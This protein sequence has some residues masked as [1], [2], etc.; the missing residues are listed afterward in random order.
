LS[1][2]NPFPGSG[3]QPDLA[4]VDRTHIKVNMAHVIVRQLRGTIG[5]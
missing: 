5:M 4:S 2:K 3:V 1:H